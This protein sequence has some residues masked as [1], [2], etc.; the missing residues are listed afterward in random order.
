M[1]TAVDDAWL[2]G[3]VVGT[4]PS[5]EAAWLLLGADPAEARR[6]AASAVIGGLG[7]T[8]GIGARRLTAAGS[9]ELRWIPV[10]IAGLDYCTVAPDGEGRWIAVWCDGID[11]VP[12][13]AAADARCAERAES[14][15]R[16]WV[17]VRR[18]LSLRH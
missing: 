8:I 9:D 11:R 1:S 7:R 2:C 10:D 13:E 16:G 5:P 6:F 15:G 17:A 4:A 3:Q 18:T 12:D 14:T